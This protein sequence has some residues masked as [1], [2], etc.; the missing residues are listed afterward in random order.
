M[1]AVERKYIM[2]PKVFV[3]SQNLLFKAT[4]LYYNRHYSQQR[5]ASELKI[6]V[7]TVSRLLNKAQKNGIIEIHIEP[8]VTEVIQ[9]EKELNQALGISEVIIAPSD[10][11]SFLDSRLAVALEGARYLQNVL[12][13]DSVLGI[14]FGGTINH[15][16][17]FLNPCKKTNTSFVMM[18]GYLTSG[19][20]Q[21][22][23]KDA[24]S[25]ISNVFS[26]RGYLLDCDAY[27]TNAGAYEHVMRKK[28]IKEMFE[29]YDKLTISISGLG[30]LG[31]IVDSG[32]ADPDNLEC[33]EITDY[34]KNGDAVGDIFLNFYDQNGRECERNDNIHIMSISFSAYRKI[35][36]KIIVVSG[37]KKTDSVLAALR[38]NL[39]DVLV[40]DLPL[41]RR[42]L[43]RIRQ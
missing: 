16:I 38:G 42:I 40:V 6:S 23:I 31:S 7:S 22:D 14:G 30:A 36:L 39:V 25:S 27:L 2:D 18:H 13:D 19:H 15:L 12:E 37:E 10:S 24:L 17:H 28:S 41:A 11:Q 32:L 26:G 20:Y 34:I 29:L 8:M 33:P 35:P 4:D 3:Q 43:E 21:E 1:Y 9:L 5:R